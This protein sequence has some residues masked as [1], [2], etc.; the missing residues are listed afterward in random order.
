VV[1]QKKENIQMLLT[2]DACLEQIQEFL[3]KQFIHKFQGIY[4][5]EINL[6]NWI[7]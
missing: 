7:Q 6:D 3:G 5:F 1:N 2:E 4:I